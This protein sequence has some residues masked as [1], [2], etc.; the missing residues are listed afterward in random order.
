M[1]TP[2]LK[3][4]LDENHVKYRTID[5]TVA[6]TAQET[7]EMAHIPGKELA[8][9]V[10]VKIDGKMAMVIEPANIK[11]NLQWMEKLLGAKK[12]ELATEREFREW[13]PECEIGAMPPMGNLFNMDVYMDD[14]LSE[15]ENIAFN[16]GTHT[17]L[18]EMRYK[19]F[20]KLVKPKM[21]HMH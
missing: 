4:F 2:K 12:V 9:T 6:F 11:L 1:L 18:V 16:A 14:K 3:H 15:D 17:D 13:F 19:D 7:A 10:I 21:L 8:K 5:H 20:E